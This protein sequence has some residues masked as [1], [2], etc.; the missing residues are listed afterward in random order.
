MLDTHPRIF[1]PDISKDISTLDLNIIAKQLNTL[2]PHKLINSSW[3]SFK[4]DTES[5]FYIAHLQ[6]TLLLKF[7]VSETYFKASTRKINDDVHLD[8]GVECFISFFNDENYYNLEFNCLGS[9]KVGYGEGRFNREL[10]PEQIL[11]SIKTYTTLQHDKTL[12]QFNWEILISVPIDVF[13][14]SN[15]KTLKGLSAKANFYKCGD[16]LPKPDY[17]SWTF[18]D[19]LEPDFHQPNFFGDVFFS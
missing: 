13:M 14:F 8:N 6:D 10:L 11:K 15:L 12:N 7:K 9:L 5:S 3:A 1:V 17:L 18:M 19:T 16:D 4:T 2:K